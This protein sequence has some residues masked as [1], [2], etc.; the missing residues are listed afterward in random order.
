[1]PGVSDHPVILS[2]SDTLILVEQEVLKTIDAFSAPGQRLREAGGI[3]LGSYRGEHLD[4]L[5]CTQPMRQDRRERFRFDR[6]DVGH[7]R[8]AQQV[9]TE[10]DRTVTYIGEWHTHPSG[11]ARPSSIDYAG[12][13]LSLR[14]GGGRKHLFVVRSP[15]HWWFGLGIGG[16]VLDARRHPDSPPVP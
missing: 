14:E 16:A 8:H 12:W 11:D 4:V 6:R 9:W 5:A 3:L 2:V 10:G 7:Q 1:M 13:R 15:T